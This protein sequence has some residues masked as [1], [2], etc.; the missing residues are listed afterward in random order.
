MSTL[1]QYTFGNDGQ[2]I[3][4]KEG[5]TVKFDDSGSQSVQLDGGSV[6]IIRE[7]NNTLASGN[8][9][10]PAMAALT[11]NGQDDGYAL[12]WSSDDA[13]FEGVVVARYSASGELLQRTEI[14]SQEVDDASVTVLPNGQFIVAW[15]SENDAT[16][17]STIYTQL[18]AANGSKVGNPVKVTSAK[19]ELEDATVSVLGENKYMVM[20]GEGHGSESSGTYYSNVKAVVYTDGKAGAVQTVLTGTSSVGEADDMALHPANDG[21]Y[22]LTYTQHKFSSDGSITPT[23]LMATKLSADGKPVA[24]TTVTVAQA[25]S[26]Y[27]NAEYFQVVETADGFLVTWVDDGSINPSRVIHTQQYDHAFTPV[28]SPVEVAGSG[29]INGS[30]AQSL[31]DGGYLLAWNIYDPN[32]AGIYVQRFNADGTAQDS[33]PIHIG[34]SASGES[35]WDAPTVLVRADGSLVVSWTTGTQSNVINDDGDFLFNQVLHVQQVNV[36]GELVG[37]ASTEIRGDEGDNTLHWVGSA[38]VTLD[39]GDGNDTAQLDGNLADFTFG[40]DKEG[41]VAVKGQQTTSLESIEQIR[42]DDATLTLDTGRFTNES[43]STISMEPASTKLSDGGYV[44]VWE[45]LGDIG[46]PSGIWLQQ[47]DKDQ[48]LVKNV[49]L[50]GA[51]GSNPIVTADKDGGY[52]V[53]WT[54]TDYTFTVQAYTNA[55]VANGTP[56]TIHTQD[57]DNLSVRVEDASITV[58]KNGTW[59]FAWNEEMR[60]S[61]VDQ[62]GNNHFS[63]GG[64]VFIQLVNPVTHAL[65]GEPISVDSAARDNAIYAEEPSVT[66]LPNGGF[67]VVWEREI[68]ATDDADIYMQRYD[69]S[70]K[71][72]GA[73]VRVNTTTAGRQT[74]SEVVVLDDSSYVVTW[75][76]TKLDKNENAISGNVFMQR[77]SA[78]G[79]KLGG[80]TQVNTAGTE[81]QGEPAITA[82]KGGGYV[83]SWATSDE[84]PHS[85]PANLY[86]QVFDKN[87]VKVG[88]QLTIASDDSNDLFPVVAATDDGGFIVTWEALSPTRDINNRNTSGDIYSQR[89][90][91]NGNSTKLIGDS[92]DNTITWTG[93]SAVILSGEDGDDHLVGGKGND[94]LIGGAGDD[95]LDGGAG[96]DTLAGGTG[97]DTY[98]VD[99]I[100]DVII[101]N[102]GEGTDTVQSSITWALGANLEH[103]TLTGSA[104]I[105]GTGNAGDNILIGNSARNVLTGG[106]GNDTL[107]GGA[108]ID[109][110]SGGTGD[111]NYVVDLLVK[112]TG[113]KA[114]VALEDTITEKANEGTDTLTLRM[115]S[116][117]IA[118]FAGTAALTLAAN[119]ENLDA[120]LTGALKLNLTGNAANN[121]LTG[122]DADNVLD[123]KAGIDTLI[124][125]KGND[126]YVIDDAQE[127]DLLVEHADEGIDTLQITYRNL[128]KTTALQVDLSQ[129][130]LL[131]VENVTV[132]GTG[133]FDITGNDGDNVLI[134]NALRNII[135]AGEGN[136]TLN[137]KG[138]GDRL[139][140]G[141][142]NDTYYVYSDKDDVIE[143]NAEAGGIDT[144]RVVSYAKN[145]YTLADNVENAIVDSAAAINLTGNSQDNVLTGNAAAN[146]L[147]GGLGA[148]TMRGG[149]GNDTYIVDNVG[150]VVVELLNEGIDTVK[151][152]IDYVLGDNLENLILLDGASKGTGNELAN[153]I[154]GND[155]DNVLDGKGGIDKLIGGKGDDTYRVDLLIKGTGGKATVVLEDT[156]TEKANEGT[157]TL[158]LR[159]GSG[160]FEHFIGSASITLGA[161]LENLDARQLGNLS[162]N[163]TGNAADNEIWGS[164]GNNVL[165]GGAGNDTLHAGDGG[166]N[167]LIG[168]LGADTM[169]GGSGKDTFKFN[170]L[171]ELGLG[172]KQDVIHD[173]GT[174]D[175]LDFSALKGYTFKGTGAFDGA[176]QLRYEVDGDGGI[177]V[178]GNSNANTAP[179]FSIK[180]VGVTE[181]HADQLTL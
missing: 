79:A 175:T 89:F 54:A 93:D 108:G 124:G 120:S 39:G 135:I 50:D 114:T 123:G 147:D 51:N 82:L 69:D 129:A 10:G 2:N 181:L 45:Q 83:I 107:D 37:G 6:Q 47:Y 176:K 95:V 72:I 15:A 21:G 122:N 165:N 178:Y 110:L 65:I 103:L 179:D 59:V 172:D 119:L 49:L 5:A 174:D 161:N 70:G 80:E 98:I 106:A 29:S 52:L 74:G 43:G 64:E 84:A 46:Q 102:E 78:T 111:D 73:N 100:K 19:F 22:W 128:S 67:V 34:N 125:G 36:D 35:L 167:V 12:V 85:G 14:A 105:N 146:I 31:P 58:L 90:D 109:T 23:T 164:G 61:W 7:A 101:E 13:T 127:L 145:S 177:T 57:S 32:G 16:D 4:I 142:G 18:F 20:W 8:L 158:E 38:D 60:D 132:T 171:T 173:F 63:E 144:V 9:D 55:G 66:A 134:G 96:A 160:D 91:A 115:G 76:S 40:T 133:L 3:V 117:A 121:T 1:D 97:N 62:Q 56:V 130:S 87:G 68:D 150:D 42:F 104:A 180:L 159:K 99:N 26:G 137:G 151:S 140:G 28:G 152:S 162:I 149:K 71:A 168:G 88:S 113:A 53:G 48:D 157:D 169:Y 30:S 17:V 75:V 44:I 118:A 166:N 27:A 116:D 138:G 86:A 148:D 92:G 11:A 153:T 25:N 33:S 112:G 163:L 170:A 94:T 141:N 126:T 41:N 156:I 81:I 131:N 77:Y 136:D 154:T 139:V 155:G 24:G 143:D